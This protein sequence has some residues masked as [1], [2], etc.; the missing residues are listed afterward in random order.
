RPRAAQTNLSVPLGP[1]SK[2]ASWQHERLAAVDVR[3]STAQQVLLHPESTRLQYGLVT[4]AQAYGWASERIVVIDDDLGKSGTTTV[5]RAGFERLVR[6]VRLGHVGLILGVE[7]S[8]LARSNADWR[9]L[10]EVCALFGAL[11]ADLDGRYDPAR[12]NDRLL[13]GLKG[14]MSEAERQLL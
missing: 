12:Y 2:I 14:T 9:R 4:Q 3:Q 8:R 5:G 7:M 1:S 11:I 6:E 13:L 10:L